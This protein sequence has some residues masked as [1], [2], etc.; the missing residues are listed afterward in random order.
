MTRT[1]DSSAGVGAVELDDAGA[2]VAGSDAA[3]LG[4]ATLDIVELDIAGL[5][6]A[7]SGISGLDIIF[8]ILWFSYRHTIA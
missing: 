7:K 8:S 5:E 3:G 1:E 4:A 6:A 2:D